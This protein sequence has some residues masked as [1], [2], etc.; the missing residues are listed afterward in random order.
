MCDGL[1]LVKQKF[2]PQRN[3]Q[4]SHLSKSQLRLLKGVIIINIVSVKCCS[5]F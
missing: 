1:E 5:K 3:L 4:P 2:L